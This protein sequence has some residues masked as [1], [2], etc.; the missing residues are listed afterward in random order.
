MPSHLR[1]TARNEAVPLCSRRRP[2]KSNDGGP[3][4][5]SRATALS[6][7]SAPANVSVTRLL[8]EEKKMA[9]AS[10]RISCH[11]KREAGMAAMGAR[12]GRDAARVPAKT[13]SLGSRN[14]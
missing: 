4:F 7:D 2:A 12:D 14:R 10:M 9:E 6:S 3:T 1:G 5:C 8:S 13:E 11:L